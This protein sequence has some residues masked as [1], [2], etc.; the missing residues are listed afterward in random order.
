MD[1]IVSTPRSVEIF[2][3]WWAN[4]AAHINCNASL[5]QYTRFES[6]RLS[7][8]QCA[9]LCSDTIINKAINTLSKD[10]IG[11]RGRFTILE[12]VEN[13]QEVIT[14]LEQYLDTLEFWTV[15]KD[16]IEKT[17]IYGGCIIFMDLGM[18]NLEASLPYQASTFKSTP[19]SRLKVIEP[20]NFVPEVVDITNPL[21]KYYMA[22]MK[23]HVHGGVLLNSDFTVP[24]TLF[25]VP[26]MYKPYYNYMGISLIQFM[27]PFVK[28]AETMREALTDLFLRFRTYIIK[29][30][31]LHHKESDLVK[32]GKVIIK[33]ANNHGFIMMKKDDEFVQSVTNIN[34]LEAFVNQAL[35]N[36]AIS[37]RMPAVKLLGLTPQGLNNTGE[38][39]L[40]NY[41]DE[42]ESY[43]KSILVHKVQKIAQIALWSLGYDYTIQFQFNPIAQENL[44]EKTTR[45][46][47]YIDLVDKILTAGLITE[48]KAFELLQRYGILDKS[49]EIDIDNE[50]DNN[51]L[52]SDDK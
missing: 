34:G 17:L 9:A 48:Q 11:N 3:S 7:Y 50:P 40:K 4:H 21:S 24:L 41:Y 2:D 19:L 39:D 27:L 46:N 32:R 14:K 1:T 5:A 15:M 51:D 25:N 29:T 45:E 52:S 23:W 31:D 12:P 49:D 18:G 35:Q 6:Q 37:A 22:P 42:I 44:S 13:A 36:L 28:S 26:D 16:A 38:F 43:Q 33:S 10:I 30:S 47:M 8:N 20:W